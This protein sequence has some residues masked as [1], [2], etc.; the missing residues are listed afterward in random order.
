MMNEIYK[1]FLDELDFLTG[2]SKF[3][4]KE[5]MSISDSGDLVEIVVRKFLREV[6]GERYTITHGYIYSSS[7]KELSPQIDI[8]ITDKLVSNS[9][10]KFEYLDNMEIVPIEAVIGMFEVKRNLTKKSFKD[11]LN[12]LIKI[13]DFVPVRKDNTD[14][15]LPGGIAI[16]GKGG[17]NI[18]GGK[19]SNPIIGIISLLNETE[20]KL[21]EEDIPFFIDLV[22]SFRGYLK[23]FTASQKNTDLKIGVCRTKSGGE[24]TKRFAKADNT[25]DRQG[26]LKIFISYLMAYLNDVTGRTFDINKYF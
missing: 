3:L 1:L 19:Y 15:Y 2:H 24:Y 25:L 21:D 18:D 4:H 20:E 7:K 17:I 8:I 16:V 9:F 10:K 23:V 14:R 13:V 26:I 22:F 5:A 6:L 12:H 11:A